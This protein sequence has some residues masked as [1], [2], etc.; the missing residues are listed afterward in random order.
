MMIRL[1]IIL[2]AHSGITAQRNSKLRQLVQLIVGSAK[3]NE[4]T[5][6]CGRRE[7]NLLAPCA[8]GTK[9]APGEPAP[10]RLMIRPWYR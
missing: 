3:P 5:G 2:R 8:S 6:D 4:Q 9:A 10:P 1:L 7:I